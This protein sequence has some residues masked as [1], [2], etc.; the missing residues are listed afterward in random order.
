M[1]G[2]NNKKGRGKGKQVG[3]VETNQSSETAS[4]MLFTSQIS[5]MIGAISCNLDVEKNGWIMGVTVNSMSSTSRQTGVDN[6][7]FDSGAQLHA[8]PTKYSGHKVS[9]PDPGIHTANG[10]RL[11]HDA[12]RL[13]VI[14][15][16]RR[17]GN[18]N[19]LP[20]L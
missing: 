18:R 11:H 3:A 4:N 19:T 14:Q 16:S 5:R 8:C 10:V 2:K 1:K 13:S 15:T 17:T 12:E 7:L 9:W 20:C 6:L